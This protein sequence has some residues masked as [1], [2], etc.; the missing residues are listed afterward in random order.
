MVYPKSSMSQPVSANVLRLMKMVTA[1]GELQSKINEGTL[2]ADGP[3]LQ[4]FLVARK[5]DLDAAF[6]QFKS[7]V[8]WR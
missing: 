1:D 8:I 6:K 5:G 2:T 3:T 7:T 4:R